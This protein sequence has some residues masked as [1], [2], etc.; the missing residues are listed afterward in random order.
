MPATAER[1]DRSAPR[2]RAR[3]TAPA[4]ISG[5]P[6]D[7]GHG[8]RIPPG[9][10]DHESFRKWAR[11]VELSRRARLAFYRGTVW[12]D[13]DMERLYRHNRVKQAFNLGLGGLAVSQERGMYLPDGMLLSNAAAGLSN[14]PDGIY[15]SLEAL[16][17][18]RVQEVDGDTDDATE[19]VGSPEM[20][21][22]I[23][24]DSSEKKDMV[25]LPALYFAAGIWE[26]WIVDARQEP[27]RFEIL[28]RGSRGFVAVK[29]LPGGWLKSTVFGCDFRLVQGRNRLGRAE[30]AL[31]WR[32]N[33]IKK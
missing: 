4:P 7:L 10:V 22:E 21:L 6:I 29:P 3:K 9:I 23:V 32:V 31:E 5:C 16:E 15:V 18:G 2:I 12:V 14:I 33:R 11:S 25:D 26:Y 1:I 20:T 30:Y 8:I 19:L 27:V 28:R 24:S 13:A 17:D